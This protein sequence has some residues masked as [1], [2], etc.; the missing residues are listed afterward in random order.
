FGTRRRQH[1]EADQLLLSD[2]RHQQPARRDI[3]QPGWNRESRVLC[4]LLTILREVDYPA[5]ALEKAPQRMARLK[6]LFKL[7]QVP[8]CCWRV[9]VLGIS[10][11]K[12]ACWA[13]D[14]VGERFDRAL[15]GTHSGLLGGKQIGEAQPLVAVVVAVGKEI[16]ADEDL[17][18]GA[19]RT[20]GKQPT[21]HQQGREDEAD[22]ECATPAAAE[23]AHVVAGASNAE[24]IDTTRSKCGGVEHHTARE[25]DVNGPVAV[26][27]RR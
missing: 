13:F 5:G 23:V 6:A 22:L 18:L 4:R 10:K 20:G 8:P 14:Q 26:A 25:R 24:K 15:C 17:E 1:D 3:E 7:R 16:L 9:A 12:R 11:P 19:Q 27:R 2:D 21:E